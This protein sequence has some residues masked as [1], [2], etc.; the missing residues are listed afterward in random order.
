MTGV[1][2]SLEFTTNINIGTGMH[3][4]P[5]SNLIFSEFRLIIDVYLDIYVMMSSDLSE[6]LYQDKLTSNKKPTVGYSIPG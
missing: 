4:L 1:S 2:V 3:F 6:T 5:I